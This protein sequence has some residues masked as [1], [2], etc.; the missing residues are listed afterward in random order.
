[1]AEHAAPPLGRVSDFEVRLI[2]VFKA[3]VECG[4]FTAA[5]GQL[6]ISRSA[7]SLHMSDL[8]KRLGLRLCQR[9]RGGFALTEEGRQV[10]RAGLALLA[11]LETFRTE[12]NGLHRT[13]RGELNIGITD[14]LVSLPQMRITHALSALKA[15]GPEVVVN[16]YMEAPDSIAQG[17]LDARLHI[18][19]VPEVN[20]LASLEA[21]PLYDEAS[22]LYC[23]DTHPLFAVPD[24]DLATAQLAGFEA[25]VPGY[26]LPDA[27]RAAHAPLTGTA[28]ASDRE[29]AAFMI[30][31]GAY[32]GYL[33]DHLAAHWVAAGRLRE[34]DLPGCRFST[35]FVTIT[36]RDRRP[37][38]V[39][40]AFIDELANQS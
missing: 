27:A 8:E 40:E 2:R 20:L 34:L 21:R 38:R 12:V 14:N 13:L 31:T 32:L 9:G 23:A 39:L 3:V 18:G 30:L 25:V 26:P 29:G 35:P 24:A 36:R 5:E 11:S 28:T 19:V 17:V 10:Y 1:M 33:P 6:G 37:H 22:G 7:I 4:G 15:Q 16:I